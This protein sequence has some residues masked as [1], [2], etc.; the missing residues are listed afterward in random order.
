MFETQEVWTEEAALVGVI[1]DGSSL[2]FLTPSLL[3]VFSIMRS[4]DHTNQG[5]GGEKNWGGAG[6]VTKYQLSKWETNCFMGALFKSCL[7]HQFY[8]ELTGTR[9]AKLNIV[10]WFSQD[11]H[12]RHETHSH[13]AASPW[14]RLCHCQPARAHKLHLMILV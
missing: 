11:F 6:T 12:S 8:Y 1:T 9:R 2:A 7:G 14:P 13:H 10:R 5:R 4:S 3:G